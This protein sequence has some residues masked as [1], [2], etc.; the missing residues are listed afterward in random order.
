MVVNQV[1]PELSLPLE[2]S[3][4]TPPQIYLLRTTYPGPKSPADVCLKLEEDR[5][6]RAQA[7]PE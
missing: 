2:V 7:R 3:T 1:D 6:T 5:P 4:L